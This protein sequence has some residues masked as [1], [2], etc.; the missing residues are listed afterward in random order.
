LVISGAGARQT[1]RRLLSPENAA[2][3]K[4]A[5]TLERIGPS[6]S[7]LCLFV[8]LDGGDQELGLRTTNLWDHHTFDHDANL[9]AFL[10]DPSR[11]F[12]LVYLSFQS[13]KDPTFATRYPGTA[14]VQ[15]LAPANYDWFRHWEATAW[16]RRGADYD[17]LK[18]QFTERLLAKLYEHVPQA[19]GRVKHAELGTPLSTRHFANHASG[20]TY[21]LAH[22]PERFAWRA[23]R[24]QTPIRGLYLSGVD[25]AICGIAGA[26]VS[27]S[28]T[29]SAILQKNAMTTAKTAQAAAA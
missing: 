16:H 23:L 19:R 26:L 3:F 9:S 7:M 2:A 25:V 10:A 13:A 17:T 6:C 4:S 29:A 11:P 5:A 27:G 18:Q 24:P 14:A 21:G 22:S 15:V 12:P 28:L 8:A 20:E 1:F